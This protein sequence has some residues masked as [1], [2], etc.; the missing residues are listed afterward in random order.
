MGIRFS[1]RVK[2]LPG[3]TLNISKT[4]ASVSVGPKGAKIN[5]SKK[6]VRGTVGLPGSGASY[7]K[8]LVERERNK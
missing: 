3:V 1:K 2:L 7:S 8:Q 6:G 4:G 5:I